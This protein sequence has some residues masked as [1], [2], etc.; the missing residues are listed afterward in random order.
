VHGYHVQRYEQ[1]N[2]TKAEIDKRRR[3]DRKRKATRFPKGSHVESSATPVGFQTESAR[4]PGSDSGSVS[5][6]VS[7]GGPG[8]AQPPPRGGHNAANGSAANGVG[9]AD[10]KGRPVTKARKTL[11]RADWKPSEALLEWAKTKEN[12]EAA[13]LVE[14]FVD[15]WLRKGE[16]CADWDAAFRT[17]V[18]N[19]V[20]FGDAKPAGVTAVY[21]IIDHGKRVT[22]KS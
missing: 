16:G 21:D 11:L 2:E 15:H 1:H 12:V 8:G 7:V 14:S 3:I 17:W 5:G 6:S 10:A 22:V 4:P 20:K 19:A 13:P 18:R 9:H